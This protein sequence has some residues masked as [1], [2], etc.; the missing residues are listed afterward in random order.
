[1]LWATT[2]IFLLFTERGKLSLG[3]K[4]LFLFYLSIESKELGLK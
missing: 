3:E 1:M 4:Y 2:T